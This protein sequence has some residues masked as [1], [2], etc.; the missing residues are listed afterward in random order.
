[1]PPPVHYCAL[2]LHEMWA[3]SDS[4][5]EIAAALGCSESHVNTLARRHGLPRRQRPI[6]EIFENDPTPNEIERLKAEIKA[7][8]M[9]EMRAMP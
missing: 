9:A 6:K 4:N 3:R 2:R 1:M 8:H 5:Q 7:R